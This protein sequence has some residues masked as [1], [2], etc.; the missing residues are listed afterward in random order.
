MNYIVS[1]NRDFFSKI[2]DYN[3]CTIGEM[4]EKLTAGL[5]VDTETTGLNCRVDKMFAMQLGTGEDNFLIDLQDYSG[6]I[7]FK[8]YE[9]GTQSITEVLPLLQGRHLVFHNAMFDLGFLMTEG[10]V[11]DPEYIWDT[12]VASRIIYNG[13]VK[14]RHGFGDVMHRELGVVYDKSEQKNI[15]RV[16]LSTARAIEYCFNDVDRL[17]ELHLKLF[18]RLRSYGGHETYAINRKF[19][20]P[21]VY[22]E[23]CGLPINKVKWEQKMGRDIAALRSASAAVHEYICD[24][25]PHLR[26][27]QLDLLSD[28]K[29]SK[30]KLS[31]PVQPIDVFKAFGIDTQTKDKKT[32]LMKDSIDA[33]VIGLSKHEFVPLWLAYKLEAHR[34][35]NQGKKILNKIEDGRIYVRFRS[36][37]D[38]SRIAAS[39]AGAMNA[40]NIPRDDGFDKKDVRYGETRKC[41]EANAGFDLVVCD[42]EGQENVVLADR[43][44]DAM[45]TAS[46]VNG[47]DL[48]CAFARVFFPELEHLSD[49]EIK[50]KHSSKRTFVKAPRFAFSY[51]G[52]GFTVHKA[53]GIPLADAEKLYE[54]FKE[55]H[56]GVFE[57]GLKV[58]NEAVQVGYIESVAGWRLELP[59]FKD[60]QDLQK[61]IASMT[62]EVRGQYRIGKEEY[63]A[64]QEVNDRIAEV[65]RY[66]KSLAEGQKPKKLPEPYFV[67]NEA[68]Y[69]TYLQWKGPMRKMAQMRSEY[70][71]LCL[72]NPI[73]TTGAHQIKLAMI[74]LFKHIISR[75]HLWR[76]RIVNAPYDEIVL[77]VKNALSEEYKEVLGRLMREAGDHFLK[78]LKIG[79]QAN[80]GK[81]WFEAK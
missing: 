32:G 24:K 31:S 20:V 52:T 79:A 68:A 2:G 46:V 47:L 81:S 56:A 25:L 33:G 13:K 29:V 48:H 27:P 44:G 28:V 62:K 64:E 9:N 60:F 8:E 43:S 76:A 71:R 30:V 17:K 11:P 40:L 59:L 66:N 54:G 61:R 10:F 19:L 1:R 15:H 4:A 23:L 37:V 3:Y 7:K 14:Y 72:N 80:I 55:L 16:R 39:K 69:E 49:A 26:N 18:N 35:N 58:Y 51:G 22:M 75:G 70:Q 73:Q 21:L 78:N 41:F 53:T 74:N 5:A 67:Q 34:V 42:F 63:K 57:Y 45:M 6:S 36:M 38:T 50:E 77:E 65:K 12:L